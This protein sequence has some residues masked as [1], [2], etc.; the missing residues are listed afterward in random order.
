MRFTSAHR[1]E[2]EVGTDGPASEEIGAAAVAPPA[3]AARLV[4]IENFLNLDSGNGEHVRRGAIETLWFATTNPPNKLS[5]CTKCTARRHVNS[6]RF[7]GIPERE[8]RQRASVIPFTLPLF[9]PELAINADCEHS[10]A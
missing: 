8:K 6:T 5:V 9:V 1:V 2:V 3:G 10:E 7:V 4:H